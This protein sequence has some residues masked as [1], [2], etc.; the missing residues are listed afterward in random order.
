MTYEGYEYEYD[1][2]GIGFINMILKE[3]SLKIMINYYDFKGDSHIWLWLL[4]IGNIYD[5]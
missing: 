2:W 3:D 1:L 4:S 5:F